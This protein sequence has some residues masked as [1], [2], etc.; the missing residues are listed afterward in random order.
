LLFMIDHVVLQPLQTYSGG[1]L[2]GHGQIELPR[3]STGDASRVVGKIDFA[4]RDMT[5]DLAARSQLVCEDI[6]VAKEPP[7]V[8]TMVH[9]RDAY[10]KLRLSERRVN[11]AREPS[12][13][14]SAV[15]K[16]RR[17]PRKRVLDRSDEEG[18]ID[19]G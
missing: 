5:A 15:T 13:S 9:D 11:R 14:P 4:S 6:L 10:A 7:N 1:L 2:M 12:P 16:G 17:T 8:K 18:V 19:L 3:V